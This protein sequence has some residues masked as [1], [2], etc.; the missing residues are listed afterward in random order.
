MS[1]NEKKSENSPQK[2][3]S[4]MDTYREINERER[5]EEMRRQ[6]ELD[7]QKAERE[8]KERNAYAEKLRQERLELLKLKQGVISEDDVP[9]EEA[10]VKQY[11][12]KEKIGNF[13]YHNKMYIIMF[14]VA[15]S[16]MGFLIYDLVTKVDPD[17]TIMF[18]AVDPEFSLYTEEMENVLVRYCE[19]YNGD[20][21]VKVRVSY[22]P[23]NTDMT[24]INA[25]Y[26]QADRTKIIAEFQGPDSIIVIND[27][28]ACK[29]LDI[30]GSDVF[31]DLTEY[32]PD[33]E[34]AG[35]WGYNLSATNIA[36]DIGYSEMPDNLTLS[37]RSPRSGM[38]EKKFRKNFEGA[39]SLWTNYING[40]VIDPDAVNAE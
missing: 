9:K 33:D 27:E 4:F 12:L 26:N 23:A 14:A 40:N 32:Y 20:G 16:I 11:T 39:V 37:F 10:V 18:V 31:A 34:N 29:V 2:G 6:S 3:K 30:A 28:E 17:V 5:A 19:D 21:K 8:R 7:A 35:T 1:E 25:Q 24:G 22:I 36:E 13:F 15:A 38:N